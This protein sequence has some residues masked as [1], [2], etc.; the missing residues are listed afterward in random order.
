MY[1][2]Q[3]NNQQSVYIVSWFLNL[4]EGV[5][6][7]D[8]FFKN[9]ANSLDEAIAKLSEAVTCNAT[10]IYITLSEFADFSSQ[11]NEKQFFWFFSV[12]TTK[13]R[14]PFYCL[15]NL[16]YPF[17]CLIFMKLFFMCNQ[18]TLYLSFRFWMEFVNEVCSVIPLSL[19]RPY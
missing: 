6:Y 18:L 9:Q 12:S 13:K 1:K 19:D 5:Q 17:S 7:G 15:S 11:V 3:D 16:L 14:Q 10:E 2:C 8:E 4:V